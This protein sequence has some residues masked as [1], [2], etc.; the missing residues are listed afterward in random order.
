MFMGLLYGKKLPTAICERE[1]VGKN[2]PGKGSKQFFFEKNNQKTFAHE[3]IRS[4]RD[5]LKWQ[6]F[7]LLFPKRSAVFLRRRTA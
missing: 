2:F 5:A 3:G 6:K 1:R 4:V 7:L